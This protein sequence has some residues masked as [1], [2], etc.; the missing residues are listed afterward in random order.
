MKANSISFGD[1]VVAWSAAINN[2]E[3]GDFQSVILSLKVGI[4]ETVKFQQLNAINW[5]ENEVQL[6][7]VGYVVYPYGRGKVRNYH[8]GAEI[9]LEVTYNFETGEAF[10]DE[11]KKSPLEILEKLAQDVEDKDTP[12]FLKNGGMKL[13][14]A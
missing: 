6:R 14:N 13:P 2:A 11:F 12:P 3:K 4:Y 9:S 8:R 5:G 7:G 10:W 1:I